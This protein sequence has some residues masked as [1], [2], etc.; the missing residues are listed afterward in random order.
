MNSC[1]LIAQIQDAPKLRKTQEGQTLTE[2]LVSFDGGREDDPPSSLKVVVWGNLAEE[3][4][5]NYFAGDRVILTGRL[6]M[7]MVERED[8]G[9]AHRFKEKRAELT[10]SSFEKLSGTEGLA[11]VS[12]SDSRPNNVIPMDSYNKPTATETP[13]SSRSR[14]TAEPASVA[15]KSSAPVDDADLDDIPF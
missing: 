5:Q 4:Y 6:K 1:V 9:G 2:M 13:A 8:N 11:T 7:M 10:A 12:S 3:V 15:S 14:T